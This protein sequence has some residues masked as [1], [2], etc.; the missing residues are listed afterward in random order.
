VAAAAALMLSPVGSLAAAPIA[1]VATF[2]VLAD[3]VRAVGGEAVTVTALV[4]PNSDAHAFDPTPTDV[5]KVAAAGLVVANGLGLEHWL[6]RVLQ[7]SGAHGPVVLA[8]REAQP[9]SDPDHPGVV[10]PHVWQ[11]VANAERMVEAIRAGL[12]AVAPGQAA[13][14]AARAAAV[15][16]DLQALDAEIRAAWAAIPPP[17]RR[18][19][20]SHDA[21]GYYAAA[22]GVT[23]IAPVG[24]STEA[25][26]SAGDVARIIRQIRAAKAKAVFVE[27]VTNPKL[28]Q[29]IARESGA[30]VGGQVYSDAL[31]AADGPAASYIAMMRHNTRLFTT[32]VTAGPPPSR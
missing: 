9:L 32:A 27:N 31:S 10:D 29:Q 28:M 5:R 16:R 4:G 26:P 8:A 18:I 20:T 25:E 22:Y 13:G 17:D 3:L 15:T 12:S 2:S 24:V 23:L 11:S 6:D 21:F 7:A 1:V 19:F 30:R 14:F